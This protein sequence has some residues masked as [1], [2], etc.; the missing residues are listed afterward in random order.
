MSNSPAVGRTQSDDFL[1]DYPNSVPRRD[2]QSALN[3]IV[4]DTAT[5]EVFIIKHI[6]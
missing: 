3:K 1:N 6:T 4:Q 5:Y 2:E